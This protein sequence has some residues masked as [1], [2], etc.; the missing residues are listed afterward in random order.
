MLKKLIKERR[1]IRVF[2]GKKIPEKDIKK[3][4]EAGIWAPTGC[5]NQELRFLILEDM[6]EIKQF[7]PYLRGV[8]NFILIFADMSLPKSKMYK[9]NHEKNLQYIDTGLALQNMVLF[10]KSIGI[11]SCI[12]NLS[13]YHFAITG[14]IYK[15][16]L[17]KIITYLDLHATR[18]N[19][20]EYILK[21]KLR[22][23][24]HFEVMCGVALGYG[25]IEPDINTIM[26]GGKKI[27]RKEVNYY[28][29]K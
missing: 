9:S 1:S 24:K 4:I 25:K 26:H 10:A 5:N 2:T 12:C 17:N 6:E 7:K 20:F 8:S 16:I 15:K 28:L 21:N 19:N 3:I 18:K 22:V 11:D 29:I 23:P 13:K 27:M 14:S